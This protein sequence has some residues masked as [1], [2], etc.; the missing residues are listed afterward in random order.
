MC[1]CRQAACARSPK[2]VAVVLL[3]ACR[4]CKQ[5]YDKSSGRYPY[6]GVDRWWDQDYNSQVLDNVTPGPQLD[7]YIFYC[8]PLD[9]NVL[10]PGVRAAIAVAAFLIL[11]IVV[12]TISYLVLAKASKFR[13]FLAL[14]AI[15]IKGP[16][17][18]GR[19]SLVV[20]DIEG[21]SGESCPRN[22]ANVTACSLRAVS[23]HQHQSSLRPPTPGPTWC[24]PPHHP[25]SMHG[26]HSSTVEGRACLHCITPTVTKLTRCEATSG[27]DLI[28]PA[29]CM[30]VL[31]CPA[32][33]SSSAHLK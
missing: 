10:K 6:R 19:M 2:C 7:M 32:Q 5:F 8:T 26:L 15:R 27:I 31:C 1:N 20:T 25:P 28:Y 33:T 18:S 22:H 29:A 9:S 23:M 12:G 11:F 3:L 13:R 24:C 16:P 14:S 4:V 30:P 21:Y 17:R